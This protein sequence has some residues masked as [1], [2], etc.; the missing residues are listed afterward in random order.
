[1]FLDFPPAQEL[2]FPQARRMTVG[3]VTVL[4]G[5]LVTIDGNTGDDG[6][7]DESIHRPGTGGEQEDGMS[8]TNQIYIY[9]YI[10]F[11]L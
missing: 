10:W 6:P 7:G 8:T 11:N 4:E 3:D 5:Q 9:I 1:M 2:C